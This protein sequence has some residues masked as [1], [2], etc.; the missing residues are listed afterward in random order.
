MARAFHKKAAKD[1]PQHGIAKGDMYWF[2]EVKTGPRSSRTIRSK[3][4]IPR[5]QLTSS[6]FLSTAYDLSDRLDA[7][8]TKQDLE[9]IKSEFEDLREETQGSLDNMPD[10]LQ[11]GS[12]GELL[13]E[14]IDQCEALVGELEDAINQIEE[15]ESADDSED[16]DARAEEELVREAI[17]NSVSSGF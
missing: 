17:D 6:S 14:R 10:G 15:A 4:P 7:C 9:D 12:T 13:Q 3:N 16:D 5:S 8:Q 2:A 1:Y 11:Q